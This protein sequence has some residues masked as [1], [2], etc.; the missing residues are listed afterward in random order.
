MIACP[1]QY[2]E[3]DDRGRP[4][5]V[6]AN[7]KV[8]EVVLDKVAYGWDADEIHRQHPYLSLAQIYAAFAYYYDHKAEIDAE[9]QAQIEEVDR[10]RAEA[11]E[12]P[13][14]QRMRQEGRLP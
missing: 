6:G 5:I 13:F 4:W 14:V 11:G 9:I 3:L 7:T 1:L 10:L 12:S 8:V 2:I